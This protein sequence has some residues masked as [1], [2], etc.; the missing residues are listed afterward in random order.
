MRW[1]REVKMILSPVR[2]RSMSPGEKLNPKMEPLKNLIGWTP[3]TNL[4]EHSVQPL[5]H[6]FRENSKR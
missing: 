5:K 6:P 1:S 3:M 2:G 4:S